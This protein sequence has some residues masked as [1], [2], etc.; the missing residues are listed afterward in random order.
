MSVSSRLSKWK[1]KKAEKRGKKEA[2]FANDCFA[3]AVFVR[4]RVST[5]LLKSVVLREYSECSGYSFP[6]LPS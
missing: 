4:L 3:A 6:V 2:L 5:F 1:Q